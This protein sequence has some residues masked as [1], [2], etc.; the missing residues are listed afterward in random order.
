MKIIRLLYALQSLLRDVIGAHDLG[1]RHVPILS[2]LATAGYFS[3]NS[4]QLYS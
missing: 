1:S 4:L 3:G 2:S